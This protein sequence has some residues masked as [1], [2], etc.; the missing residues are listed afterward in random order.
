MLDLDVLAAEADRQFTICNACRYC[1]DYCP[2]FPA[3]ERR[4][5]FDGSQLGQLANLCHDCRACQQACMYTEPHE[6][7]INIPALMAEARVASYERYARPRWLRRVFEGGP[8]ALSAATALGVLLLFVVYSLVSTLSHLVKPRTG[9]GALYDTVGHLT[10]IVPALM[11]AAY[12]VAVLVAGVAAFWAASGTRLRDMARPHVWVR[13]LLE[14]ATLAGMRGGGGGC[15]FPSQ[16]RPSS[17][18]R[19][20]HSL[21]AYG[22]L[23]TFAA[24]VAA[25]VEEYSLG[26]QPPYPVLSAPVLLGL[27][28]GVLATIG[29]LGLLWLKRGADARLTTDR[30]VRL[31]YGLLYSLLA[32]IVSGMALFV[33]RDTTVMGPVLLVHLGTILILYLT[34]PY[35]KMVHAVYR[36]AALMT[37]VSERPAP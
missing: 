12:G 32:V 8:R 25:F 27:I 9:P 5:V 13:A 28:G 3:M 22:F 20:L 35:G 30:A 11:L 7:R 17:S 29:C 36:F 24:T 18:R 26:L 16:E 34:I 14:A 23:L 37:D 10:M 2:V 15:Y 4:S 6:F 33:T 21:L 1:E 19:T 31:E